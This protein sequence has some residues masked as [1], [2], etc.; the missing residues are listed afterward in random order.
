M[1]QNISLRKTMLTTAVCLMSIAVCSQNPY[2]LSAGARQVGLAYATVA[3][4]G[5]WASFH[6]QASLASVKSWSAGINQD[7]RFGL[8]ELSNKTFAMIIPSHKRGAMGMVYSY[9]GYTEY[10][11]H[12]IGLAYG[13]KL[14]NKIRAGVQTDFYSTRIAGDYRNRNDLSFEGGIQYIP[15]NDLV[16]GIHLYN[17]IPETLHDSDIP[18]VMRLGASYKFASTFLVIA[19]ME[20]T[21]QANTNARVAFEY[22]FPANLFLRGGF[23]SN[24]LGYAFGGGYSGRILQA[25]LGFITHE[26][27]GL[28]PSL[29][30]VIFIL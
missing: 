4:D 10:N 22:E 3:T 6:N 8:S 17:P 14:G 5:F 24:P 19:E 9:Y 30:L 1:C 26:N 27:L 18:L 12:T 25:N 20:T 21:N 29:S 15:V 11:R 13:M 23:M 2:R 7:N 16:L 28:T